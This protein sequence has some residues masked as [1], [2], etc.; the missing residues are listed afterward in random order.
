[1]D[2]VKD[3]TEL[4]IGGKMLDEDIFYKKAMSDGSQKLTAMGI[5][6]MRPD[7]RATQNSWVIKISCDGEIRKLQIRNCTDILNAFD[8]FGVI[9]RVGLFHN[10]L[11]DY[12]H[13]K[14]KV[15]AYPNVIAEIHKKKETR[16]EKIVEIDRDYVTDLEVRCNHLLSEDKTAYNY[17]ASKLV[18]ESIS[19]D[20]FINAQCIDQTFN[21][22]PRGF[23]NEKD[24]DEI[25]LILKD[26][27]DKDKPL[28]RIKEKKPT[29][30]D[31]LRPTEFRGLGT[32]H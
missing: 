24:V 23:Q 30:V 14:A 4:Y 32:S 21:P 6:E 27:I 19:G 8:M 16:I 7:I 10:P 1:M 18:S 13:P 29:R 28:E 15:K 25:I 22:A 5:D 3:A 11:S 12:P 9:D 2:N 20:V 17:L 26:M 31:N